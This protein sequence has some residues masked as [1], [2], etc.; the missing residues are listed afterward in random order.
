M[1]AACLILHVTTAGAQP[2]DIIVVDQNA[3]GGSGGVILVDLLTGAQTKVSSL[4]LFVNPHNPV[5]A[6]DGSIFLTDVELPGVIRVDSQ[7]GRKTC[8]RGS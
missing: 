5:L 6:E 2:D 1:V 4:G 7:T 8:N 3:F